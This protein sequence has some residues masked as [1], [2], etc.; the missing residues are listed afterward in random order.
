MKIDQISLTFIPR[1]KTPE[2]DIVMANATQTQSAPQQTKAK[3]KP[4]ANAQAQQAATATPKKSSSKKTTKAQAVQTAQATVDVNALMGQMTQI[5]ADVA[6]LRANAATPVPVRPPLPVTTTPPVPAVGM[7]Q[8]I[9]AGTPSWMKW[10]IG[11]VISFC[12]LC[13]GGKLACIYFD[14]IAAE[15]TAAWNAGWEA[16]KGR[17]IQSYERDASAWDRFC[18]LFSG[19]YPVQVGR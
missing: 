9:A 12:C 17:A 19:K 5:A 15:K 4:A 10:I 13:G 18:S 8:V 1:S 11:I 2:E 14:T 16:G 7:T 6:A 3:T